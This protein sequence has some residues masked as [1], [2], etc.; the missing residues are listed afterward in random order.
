MASSVYELILIESPPNSRLTTP[1]EVAERIH[2]D[3]HRHPIEWVED[4]FDEKPITHR[5]RGPHRAFAIGF[6]TR[7]RHSVAAGSGPNQ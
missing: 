6:G 3:S 4:A 1:Q 7:H 5:P 2:L